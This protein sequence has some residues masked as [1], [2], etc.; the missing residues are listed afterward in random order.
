VRIEPVKPEDKYG[1]IFVDT[2]KSMEVYREWLK[3]ARPAPGPNNLRRPLW[4]N[5]ALRPDESTF[6]FNDPT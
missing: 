1:D 4:M 2:N 3:M 6:Y 5:R